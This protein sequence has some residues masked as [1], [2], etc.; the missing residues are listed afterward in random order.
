MKKKKNLW[1]GVSMLIVAVLAI[2]AFIRGKAQIW[3]YI[4]AFAAWSVW[5]GVHFLIPYM[6]EQIHRY[7]ARRIRKKCERQDAGKPKFIIPDI[8]DPV[9]AVL[10]RHA[11]YRISSYLQS[12]YPDA[13]WEWRCESPQQIVAKGGTGRIKLYGVHDFNYY[14][15][16]SHV[17]SFYMLL[18]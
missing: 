1:S 15:I 8:S 7:E 2:T 13:T 12:V 16:F 10:L 14:F 4:A 3:L 9:E 5:A 11:N 6:K 17:F 18:R